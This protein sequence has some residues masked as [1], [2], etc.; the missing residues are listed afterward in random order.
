ML[1]FLKKWIKTS[2]D[3][4]I[5][6][7][8]KGT[9]FKIPFNY[10]L[11]VFA[12]GEPVDVLDVSLSGL[13]INA[14]QRY[15]IDK[16]I[17]IIL[18]LED[19]NVSVSGQVVYIH[20][21]GNLGIYIHYEGSYLNYYYLIAPLIIGCSL[22]EFSADRVNQND[23]AYYKRVFFG[24]IGSCLTLWCDK[25][26]HDDFSRFELELENF[27]VRGEDNKATV[28]KRQHD[29]PETRK[30]HK[31]A[32]LEEMDYDD[33]ESSMKFFIWILESFRNPIIREKLNRFKIETRPKA[34]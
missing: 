9:R 31:S 18:R 34:S 8:R 24:S 23:P 20:D 28:Y 17:P 25:N 14:S 16:E 10:P 3:E 30:N 15:E 32:L 21:D 5:A 33:V 1:G 26:N 12:D 11:K 13:K 29:E 4:V 22:K 27:I 19:D 7:R 2:E 6:E